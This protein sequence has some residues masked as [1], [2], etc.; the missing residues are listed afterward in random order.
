MPTVTLLEKVYGP[1][2]PETF[3]PTLS[4][5][6]KGLKVR[7][8]VVGGTSRGW[9]QIEVSGEDETVA[10]HYLSQKVGFAPTF[11]DRLTRFS[12]L[13]GRVIS[14]G[15]GTSEVY[16][17]VGVFSPKIRDAAVHLHSLRAQ[18][19]DGKMVPLERIIE[20]FCL[21]ENLPLEVKILSHAGTEE[22]HAIAELSEAQLARTAQWIR[23]GLDRLIVLGVPI[24]EVERAIRRSK[25]SRD[26]IRVE[27]LGLLENAI[28]C[29]LGTDAVGLIPKLGPLLSTATLAPFCPRKILGLIERP[30]L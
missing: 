14:S 7:L 29:K 10:L 27:A 9:I 17:D 18:L 16:V 3:Q 2:S 30:F 21:Y 19:A 1:Y 20:L 5:L 23:S 8:R 28:V 15:K 11:I 22:K 6:C 4:S 25:H 26:I 13:R 12:T 24:S